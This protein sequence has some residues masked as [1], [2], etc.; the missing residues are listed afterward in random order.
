MSVPKKRNRLFAGVIMSLMCVLSLYTVVLAQEGRSNDSYSLV[1]QKA[2]ALEDTPESVLKKAQ[3]QKYTFK[4]EGCSWKPLENGKTADDYSPEEL[5]ESRTRVRVPYSEEITL[6]GSSAEWEQEGESLVLRWKKS[7]PIVFGN[8]FDVTVTEITDNIVIQDGDDY[9][10]MSDSS[11]DAAVTVNSRKHEVELKYNSTLTISRPT[12][13]EG[14]TEPELWYHL[15]NRQEDDHKSDSFQSVDEVFS[16]P[17]GGSWKS[18]EERPGELFSAGIYTIEQIAAPDGYTLQLGDREQDVNIKGNTDKEGV[19]YINGNPGK[20]TITA[21]GT[22]G[23][24]ATHYYTVERTKTEEGDT[25]EFPTRTVEIKSQEDY[26]LG[27][28]PKGQYTVKEYS[29][30]GDANTEFSVTMSHTDKKSR[31][32]YSSAPQYTNFRTFTL[33]NDTDYFK[34]DFWGPLCDANKKEIKD[35]IITY[36]FA[37][38]WGN[39]KGGVTYSEVEGT[40]N[41]DVPY[42]FT[43]PAARY[44]H[45]NSKIIGFRTQNVSNS[46]AQYL[47]VGWTEYKEYLKTNTYSTAGRQYKD[48]EVDDRGKLTITAPTPKEGSGTDQIVYYY[49]IRN[50]KNKL[51]TFNEHPTDKKDTSIKLKAG[52]ICELKV[53]A[54]SYKITETVEWVN[55]GFTMKVEGEPFGTTEVGKKFDIQVG[56]K[57]DLIIRKPAV[58]NPPGNISDSELDKRDYTFVVSGDG[59]SENVTV[60]VKAGEQETVTLPKAGKYTVAPKDDTL[61]IYNLNYTDSG[62]VYGTAENSTS[63]VTFTNAFSIGDYAYRFVHEYYVKEPDGK[64]YTYEG[65]SE[66]FTR[67]GRRAGERHFASDIDKVTNY[68]VKD[69]TYKYT[70]FD[71]AYGWVTP[72][73]PATSINVK[74]DTSARKSE[75]PTAYTNGL[76]DS[77]TGIANTDKGATR[78]LEYAPDAQWNEARVTTDAREIIILRYYRDRQPEGKYNVIH[79]YYFRDEKG[80][81]LE[82]VS[83]I[84][85]LSD[86]LGTVHTEKDVEKIFHFTPKDSENPDGYIYTWD[87]AQYGVR[88]QTSDGTDTYTA[89]DKWSSVQS[90]TEG[91]QI[92]IL[93]YY[94]VKMDGKYKIVHEYYFREEREDSGVEEGDS[95]VEGEEQSLEMQSDAFADDFAVDDGGDEEF[96]SVEPEEKT[97]PPTGYKAL[98]EQDADTITVQVPE[99]SG[100]EP[101]ED[102]DAENPVLEASENPLAEGA[103]AEPPVLE[104]SEMPP[105]LG[106]REGTPIVNADETP[107]GTEAPVLEAVPQVQEDSQILEAIPPVQDAMPP[108]LDAVPQIGETAPSPMETQTPTASN[109]STEPEE[110]VETLPDPVEDEPSDI[111]AY[112][113]EYDAEIELFA[114]EEEEPAFAGTLSSDERYLYTFEGSSDIETR[115]APLNSYHY[116]TEVDWV[117]QW[118]PPDGVNE[119]TYH[120]YDPD[121]YGLISDDGEGY[122]YMPSKQ[123]AVSTVDGTEIIILRYFRE[124]GQPPDDP[125]DPGPTP[126]DNPPEEPDDP[127]RKPKDPPKDPDDPPKDPDDPPK[128]PETPPEEP[129]TPP[130]EPETPPEEPETPE[131]PLEEP[132]TPPETPEYP[133]ELP[134]PNDPNSPEEITIIGPNGVPLTY[135]KFWDPEKEEWVYLPEDEIPLAPM[136]GTPQTGDEAQPVLWG[137]L[138]AASLGAV[139]AMLPRNRKK[140]S[141][142]RNRQR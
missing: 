109:E 93:R 140:R 31:T 55:V 9:Y 85:E 52:E 82:G 36:N 44:P 57:R 25:S 69:Q 86:E 124:E 137:V 26:V 130:E 8:P 133:T 60:T 139:W 17:S 81:H 27:N 18:S 97:S 90:T 84:S 3:D 38:G 23:D 58:E 122:N 116:G 105:V 89:N 100:G 120:H 19:F 94:R 66:T 78:M 54:G 2:F 115:D 10:N 34:L 95:E 113:K 13:D 75:H 64:T 134:D 101:E 104:P 20:L 1:I 103:N 119:Y 107:L 76:K 125:D 15:T 24:G 142:R 6:D 141:I 106:A 138:C 43:S 22:A 131:T 62:A 102:A 47:F 28:L 41:G 99:E 50:S 53:P 71:E 12:A 112:S 11:T 127:P 126:P 49:V 135:I 14:K 56:G 110:P 45:Q 129:E 40:Y 96:A 46:R 7:N 83:G 108:V 67:R 92:I 32:A 59:L 88:T 33:A 118:T 48:I 35:T 74:E 114:E 5:N 68:K 4:I 123:W 51:L 79:E 61:G 132:E 37:Y 87:G 128:D 91:N 80:D 77:G 111:E 30:A 136:D 117:E 42:K 121:A 39:E 73:D 29:F 63:T 16:L 21:G 65:N 70:H 98:A 72:L